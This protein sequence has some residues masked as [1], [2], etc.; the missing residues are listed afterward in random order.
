L[1]WPHTHMLWPIMC[2]GVEAASRRAV[3]N[4]SASAGGML[5]MMTGMRDT[6]RRKSTEERVVRRVKG[7]RLRVCVCVCEEH[8]CVCVFVCVCE[9]REGLQAACAG[10]EIRGKGQDHSTS[11]RCLPSHTT[12]IGCRLV[13]THTTQL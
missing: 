13:T 12:T 6:G 4:C 3:L 1:F 10:G 11:L 9:E 2:M 7:C 8:V 5:L